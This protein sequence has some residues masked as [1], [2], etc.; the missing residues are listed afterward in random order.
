MYEATACITTHRPL[1]Y[2]E[3]M[4]NNDEYFCQD[5]FKFALVLFINQYMCTLAK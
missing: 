5:T 4:Y 3:C 1:R 2:M